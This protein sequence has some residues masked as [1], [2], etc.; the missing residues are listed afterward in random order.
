MNATTPASVLYPGASTMPIAPQIKT[1]D[2]VSADNTIYYDRELPTAAFVRFKARRLAKPR[3]VWVNHALIHDLSIDAPRSEAELHRQLLDAFGFMVPSSMDAPEDFLDEEREFV[4]ERYGT[5][6][7]I[8]ANGG[9]VRCGLNG[10]FQLKGIGRNPLAAKHGDEWHTHGGA[11][12]EEGIREAIW[13]EI[14]HAEL[15]LGGVR[16]LAVIAT[17]KSTKYDFGLVGN[18]SGDAPEGAIIVREPNLRPAHYERVPFYKPQD[19][20]ELPHDVERVRGAFER[21]HLAVPDGEES[22]LTQANLVPVLTRLAHRY[23]R[24]HA[25]ARARRLVHGAIT[26]SNIEITGKYIDFGT[27]T[28]FSGYGNYLV[29]RGLPSFWEDHWQYQ[30]VLNGMLFHGRKYV[31]GSTGW[32][33]EVDEGRLQ[34]PFT[35]QFD[36]HMQKY[37]LHMAGFPLQVIEAIQDFEPTYHLA[38]MAYELARAGAMK[39]QPLHTVPERM[40]DCDLPAVLRLAANDEWEEMA[41][42][43]PDAQ[44]RQRFKRVYLEYRHLATLVA[45]TLGLASD[46]FRRL[47]A[48]NADL[49]N[50]APTVLFRDRMMKQSE[51]ALRAARQAGPAGV[52]MLREHVDALLSQGRRFFAEHLE[53]AIVAYRQWAGG[54]I[55][56]LRG[57]DARA[58]RCFVDV[59]DAAPGSR[60]AAADCR[61]DG[62]G[63][64]AEALP[65][66]T[67][68]AIRLW[69]PLAHHPAS[70]VAVQL[71]T[72]DDS[73]PQPSFALEL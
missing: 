52:A 58:E 37:M 47:V 53:R 34:Q 5:N 60:L 11:S 43:L 55:T 14:T 42:V 21:L 49:R 7:R 35:E 36:G 63:V 66:A 17:G 39:R 40:G 68:Q 4:G 72:G 61:L 67:G 25:A 19:G 29:A 57:Y 38:Q 20:L 30:H 10:Y 59:H 24:Q 33:L 65:V 16:I 48:L 2:V 26:S 31:A 6:G 71:D 3:V 56:V 54:R 12:V 46:R 22:A 13:G 28:A 51:E 64:H 9:G 27:M 69:L 73:L 41:S 50:K 44:L 62:V 23:A 15:P 8:C 45:G 18:Q 1:Y 70:A 32:I